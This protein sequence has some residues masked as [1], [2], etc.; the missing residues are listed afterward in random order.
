LEGKVMSQHK[1]TRRQTLRSALSHKSVADRVLDQLA[2]SQA[3]F[4]ALMDKLDADDAGSLD[5]DYV[6][7]LEIASPFEGDEPALP[8]Q[9]KADLRKALQSALAHRRIANEVVDALEEFQV[10]FNAMLAKL[11]AQGGTLADT[12]FADT[13]GLVAVDPDASYL[14]GQHKASFR[15]TLESA[16][17]NSKLADELSDSF[18]GLQGSLNQ[19]LA[20]LDAGN[21]NGAHAGFK[22]SELDPD[23]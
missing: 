21:V 4:N 9:H 17:A 8:G 18:A 22:V 1:A 23:A 7:S 14:P 16:L 13:L 19:S 6:A 12:D 5:T 2:A 15:R 3:S 11:D 20:A 10:G